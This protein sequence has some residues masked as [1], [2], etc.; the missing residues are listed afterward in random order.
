MLT[1]NCADKDCHNYNDRMPFK[2][3]MYAWEHV[4]KCHEPEFMDSRSASNS[5]SDTDSVTK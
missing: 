1:S 4:K 2:C 3:N 5:G